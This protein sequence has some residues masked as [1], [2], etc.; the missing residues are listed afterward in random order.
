[1]RILMLSWEYPPKV[2]GGLARHVQ[3]LSEALVGLGHE[4]YVVTGECQ[5]RPNYAVEQGVRVYR[6]S[7]GYP[8]P[9]DF[10]MSV[11]QL[12]FGLLQK[13]MELTEAGAGIEIV[14]A[15]DWLVAYAA[16][17]LK[18]ALHR[19]MV[20]TIHATEYGRNHGLHND[21]QRHIS[22]VE[23]WLVYE[24]W[25]VICCS[26]HMKN[27]LQWVFQ[28]PS[29]KIDVIPNGV[30]PKN[31]QGALDKAGL[32]AFRR[33]YALPHEK[34][35]FFI[36]RLVQEKG[37]G[38]LLEA[39]PKILTFY[40]DVKMIIAGK[41]PTLDHLRERA[42]Q[43]RVDHR[44]IFTGFIDDQV[45]NKL[46]MCSDVAVFPSLY[47][48]FGIVAL[49]GMAAQVPVVV[50]DTGGLREIVEHGVNGLKAYPGNAD[51]LANNILTLLHDPAFARA[52]KEQ[53]Y[54]DILQLY[55]WQRLAVQTAEVYSRVLGEYN[56]SGWD[57][58][59]AVAP[60]EAVI[61]RIGHFFRQMARDRYA[62]LGGEGFGQ[63]GVNGGF[64]DRRSFDNEDGLEENRV[65]EDYVKV[66]SKRGEYQ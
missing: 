20:A 46:Y 15:H 28:T 2:V 1:M 41:G 5:G 43:L 33:Q 29:D 66:E 4:V 30:N 18:H 21:L 44:V 39:T 62:S 6:T 48:P 56:G 31:F 65:N 55:N 25:R 37:A 23:W 60:E 14:H 9:R 10:V 34:I 47:E 38:V 50:S 17:T 22:D 61:S 57:A 54:G 32:E 40:P 45:R 12:N 49:E 53:A 8:S 7:G 24:A 59:P 58:T 64:D 36:G 52:V 11:M 51:S 16:R 13:A 42:R 63:D 35:V 27:E 26:Q 3:E 19:P